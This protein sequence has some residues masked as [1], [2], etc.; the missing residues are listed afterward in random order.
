MPDL[1]RLKS[2]PSMEDSPWRQPYLADL[3]YGEIQRLVD[4]FV[5]GPALKIL[6]VGCGRGYLSLELAREGHDVLGID[7]DQKMIGQARK[8]MDTD[9]NKSERG[10][11]NYQ[12]Q[13]FANWKDSDY[14]FDMII[15][16]RVLHHVPKPG[17][18]LGKA[19]RSL[20]LGGRIICIEYTY[21]R[22]DHRSATWF[23]HVRRVLEQVGWYEGR[24]K[25]PK[26]VV[27]P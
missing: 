8:T 25:L 6:D 7:L 2:W 17:K 13:D 5:P 16:N 26:T 23:Y 12:V 22:F 3:T 15:F 1:R 20:R 9:P 19:H 27:L 18:A 24:K 4:E 11:L 10:P 21:D 14:K